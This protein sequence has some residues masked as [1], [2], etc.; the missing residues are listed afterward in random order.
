MAQLVLFCILTT[1]AMYATA[2]HL[3]P[4]VKYEFIIPL[5]INILAFFCAPI[6]AGLSDY[7]HR[8]KS[9]LFALLVNFCSSIVF[10]FWLISQKL[11][12]LILSLFAWGVAGN[13]YPIAISS[14]KDISKKYVNFR[15]FVGASL[16]YY[17]AGDFFLFPF[18]SFISSKM[19]LV[20]AFVLIVISI[21]L[22]LFWFKDAKDVEIRERPTIKHEIIYIY[23]NF[24]KHKVF[25][26]SLLGY[27][28]LELTMYQFTFR[29]EIPEQFLNKILPIEML[30]GTFLGMVFLRITKRSD[31]RLFVLG[32]MG[33]VFCI[34][35]L[36]VDQFLRWSNLTFL[37]L[38]MLFLGFSYALIYS[39]LYCLLTRKRHH[40]D[41]GKIF[42]M[43]DSVDALSF[44]T[45]IL[46]VSK[47]LEVSQKTIY[48]V[49]LSI[50]IVGAILL[51]IFL[52]HEKKV[53]KIDSTKRV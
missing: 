40:H 19:I 24:L 43:L 2:I 14:Y 30:I 23:H 53:P 39:C 1:Q 44:I 13:F 52:H 22:I 37:R 42:G 3:A 46:V 33:L 12:L 16:F 36:F 4:E 47:M 41:H 32:I 50:F 10:I 51:L 15:F 48:L 29:T 28:L 34:G 26:F 17:S 8:K 35:V 45:A 9:L 31:E 5:G 49:S 11:F 20:I 27:F 38:V 7:Y 25:I 21:I 6:Q 18:Q